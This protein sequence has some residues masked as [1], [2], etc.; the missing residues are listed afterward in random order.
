M[1]SLQ[2]PTAHFRPL[3]PALGIPILHCSWFENIDFPEQLSP[4]ISPLSQLALCRQYYLILILHV[5]THQAIV[6]S[7]PKNPT[8]NLLLFAWSAQNIFHR[9]SQILMFL[10]THLKHSQLFQWYIKVSLPHRCPSLI[11][12]AITK[13]EQQC[14]TFAQLC[15]F[16]SGFF[17]SWIMVNITFT[18][19]MCDLQGS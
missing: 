8:H 9:C 16:S 19:R 14:F 18:S 15:I 1:F 6:F 11:Y 13:L 4:L 3:L 17:L 5:I 12:G 7:K 10:Q 2:S